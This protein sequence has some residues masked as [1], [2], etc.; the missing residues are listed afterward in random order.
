MPGEILQCLGEI[1]GLWDREI[2]G[3]VTGKFC[4]GSLSTVNRPAVQ[5]RQTAA[6]TA[7][8]NPRR[9]E[10]AR[11]PAHASPAR[12]GLCAGDVEA[13]RAG[14][15]SHGRHGATC[16]GERGPTFLPNGN[17]ILSPQATWAALA[18]CGPRARSCEPAQ[19]SFLTALGPEL[20]S[21]PDAAEAPPQK[22]H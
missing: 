5:V 3:F 17:F 10:E 19:A 12:V 14:R 2:W 4:N 22:V 21:R 11:Q 8:P 18:H 13:A 9:L 6:G 20:G 15:R 7:A 1:W 16:R